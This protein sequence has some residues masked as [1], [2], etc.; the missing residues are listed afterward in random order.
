M[1]FQASKLE[2]VPTHPREARPGLNTNSDS[3]DSENNGFLQSCNPSDFSEDTKPPFSRASYNTYST[4]AQLQVQGNLALLGAD[5]SGKTTLFKIMNHL[6]HQDDNSLT[7][8]NKQFYTSNILQGL[9]LLYKAAPSLFPDDEFKD[10]NH[11]K[12]FCSY[13]EQNPGLTLENQWVDPKLPLM[14]E[15]LWRSELLLHKL[16]W[17]RHQIPDLN[18][19]DTLDEV[20]EQVATQAADGE[21]SFSQFLKIYTKTTG[22][23]DSI[24]PIKDKHILVKDVGGA[25]SER[26]KWKHVFD[27]NL[28]SILYCISLSEYCEYY[29]DTKENKMQDS[30]N[31]FARVVNMEDLPPVYIIFTKPDVFKSRIKYIDLSCGFQDVPPELKI[32]EEQK[33]QVLS[34]MEIDYQKAQSKEQQRLADMKDLIDTTDSTAFSEK[35]QLFAD[36][37]P[38]GT[39]TKKRKVKY[40]SEIHDS[41]PQANASLESLQKTISSRNIPADE[42]TESNHFI[43]FPVEVLFLIASFLDAQSVMHLQQTCFSLYTIGSSDLIWK[44]LCARIVNSKVIMQEN[45]RLI[46]RFYKSRYLDLLSAYKQEPEEQLLTNRELKMNCWKFLY[47]YGGSI[48]YVENLEFIQTKY[49]SLVEDPKRRA[50]MKEHMSV[51]NLLHL[52]SVKHYLK[53][54]VVPFASTVVNLMYR[55]TKQEEGT[56]EGDS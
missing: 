18:G 40:T 11:I 28:T 50:F 43:L 44:P 12:L 6:Q 26:K 54:R 17:N 8:F 36:K 10:S 7:F 21:L 24:L 5:M 34:E 27:T 2:S 32:S 16:Y 14:L 38:V 33:Q 39:H 19:M 25:L 9:L 56:T 45:E 3:S 37:Y 46:S 49:L 30:L 47:Q 55:T 35:L 20:L 51:M 23:I 53:H 42:T 48:R 15:H 31:L 22:I 52:S 41:S 13:I 1:G 4:D 29:E